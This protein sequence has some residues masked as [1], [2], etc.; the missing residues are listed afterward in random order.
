MNKFESSQ[1]TKKFLEY[2]RQYLEKRSRIVAGVSGGPDSMTLLYLLHRSETETIVVHCNYGLRGSDSDRDQELVEEICRFWKLECIS[3]RPELDRESGNFQQKA[4]DERYKIF[5]DIKREYK[6]DYIATAHHRDDQIETIL[7]KLLRGGG[8]SSWKGMDVLSG[9]FFRPLLDLSKSNILEFVQEMN[10]PFRLDGSNEESTYARNFLRHAWFPELNRFFPG[11][12]ENLLKLPDRAD[13][14][15]AMADTLLDTCI[16]GI[17][18]LN[19]DRFLSLPGNIQSVVMHRFLEK[20]IHNMSVSAGFLNSLEKLGALQSGARISIN[21][22][23][24]LMRDRDHFVILDLESGESQSGKVI[25]QHKQ[26]E[27]GFE[28]H[29]LQL[30]HEPFTGKYYGQSL[31]F[32][33]ARLQFPLTLRQWREGD[34]F[35]PLGMEGSQ[36]VSDH[37]TNRKISSAEKQDALVLETFDE[38]IVAVIFPHSTKAGQ[39]GTISESVRCSG[40]TI[41]TVTIRKK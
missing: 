11:W 16:T 19:R 2:H 29:G 20:H 32:D 17:A 27:K 28:T 12:K 34:Q 35:N 39:I 37:L 18:R 3:V 5:D 30:M 24:N 6:A 36:L 1:V 23:F 31:Q 14:F 7:Q 40:N 38:S 22:R 4:R 10:I 15:T 33:A 9:E 26:I 8:I 13:E 41:T 21:E 25:I